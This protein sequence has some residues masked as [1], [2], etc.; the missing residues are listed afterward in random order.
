MNLRLIIDFIDRYF[1]TLALITFLLFSWLIVS[2]AVESEKRNNKCVELGGM[3]I[4]TPAGQTCV[5]L[6]KIE[7]N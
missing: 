3:M 2:M 7:I 4:N 5:K 1:V 6:T